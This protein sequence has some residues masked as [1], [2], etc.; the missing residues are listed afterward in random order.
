MKAAKLR[1]KAANRQEANNTRLLEFRGA[2]LALQAWRAGEVV[3]S[4]P[5]ETGKTL[6]ALY[7]IDTLARAHRNLRASIVRKV[8]GDLDA[9]ALETFRRFI[10][11]DD[12]RTYGGE[13]PVFYEYPN[14]SR[15]WIGGMDRPG[16]AL[17]GERDV[18]YVNQA[19]ELNLE[20]WETFITR[21]TGRAGALVPGLLM[22]DCNPG[23]P[24]H[25]IRHRPQLTLIE[26]RHEDNP[27]LFTDAGVLTEQG[28]HSMAVL[29]SLTGVRYLRGRKGL[30]VQAEGVVYDEFDP[31]LHVIDEMPPSWQQWRKFLAIDFGF[32]NPFVCQFWAMDGDDRLYL[33]RE[34]YM[35][36]RL[37]EDHAGQINDLLAGEELRAAFADHDAED[38]ATL[39][40]YGIST[41][42]ASKAISS[43]IEEVKSRLKIAGDGRP[44]ILFLRS[45]LVERDE[46]LARKRLP[47]ST[48][49]EFEMYA[50][51][52]DAGGKALKE[53]PADAYN[54]GMDAMRYMVASSMPAN[55]GAVQEA[56]PK[57]RSKFVRD[58][59]QGGRFGRD[60]PAGHHRR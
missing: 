33:Y 43:G 26:S 21:T 17:S 7:L 56:N 9:T 22:G 50:W 30:W 40:R 48:V 14:D 27:V 24:S 45:A 28:G 46:E 18:I 11:R 59:L 31:V 38:R 36:G 47:A 41:V 58:D 34:I 5:Y 12:V 13:H 16:K 35:T 57:A 8:R 6:A 49:Q 20:D 37:V 19:E 15:I 25:W 29:D 53:V 32:K 3:I 23:P 2:A 44:R 55:L 39:N 54:H 1:A 52:K 51:P 42:A 10:M 4:G 60:R